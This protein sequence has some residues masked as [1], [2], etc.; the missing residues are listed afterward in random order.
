MNSGGTPRRTL[1]QRGLA[2]LA[3]SVAVATGS[4][5]IRADSRITPTPDGRS[6]PQ[7]PGRTLTLYTRPRP[8][9]APPGAPRA[10]QADH[11]RQLASGDLLDAPHGK[12]IGAVYT[13]CFCAGAPFGAQRSSSDLEFQVIQ[14][15]DGTLFGMCGGAPERGE[16]VRAIVGG[17][18]GYAGARG[19]YLERP[20]AAD[21]DVVEFVVTLAG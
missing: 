7:P 16:K 1:L 11:A 21:P 17:T 12:P 2:L 14:L 18:G 6:D 8:L 4:R 3:G 19:A 10:V 5:V 15:N 13:N 20:S 9:A